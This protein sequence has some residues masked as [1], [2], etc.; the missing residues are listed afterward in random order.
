MV[1]GDFSAGGKLDT[2][3][4]EGRQDH[5]KY[6]ETLSYNLIPKGEDIAGLKYIFNKIM[7]QFTPPRRQEN[8]LRVIIS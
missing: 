2:A 7:H 4:L 5:Y 1:W 6:L 3:F 8:G